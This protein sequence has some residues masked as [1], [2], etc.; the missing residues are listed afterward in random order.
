MAEYWNIKT[1]E[2]LLL[3]QHV[4]GTGARQKLDCSTWGKY[5]N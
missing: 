3:A 4:L 1:Y 5:D 2:I